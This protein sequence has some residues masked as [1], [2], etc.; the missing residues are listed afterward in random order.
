MKSALEGRISVVIPLF[1]GA[2]TLPAQLEGL[3]NQTYNGDWEVVI[4]DNGSTDGGP[5][6]ARE[7][8]DRVPQL[9]VVDASITL[10][11]TAARNIG[12]REASGVFIAYCDADDVVAPEWLQQLAEGA[13]S[14]D[15]VGG[16]LETASLN[17]ER[18]RSWRHPLKDELPV[19]MRFLPYALS[20]NLG[21]YK[22]VLL[23]LGGWN[24]V[25]RHG[26]DDIELCWRAQLRGYKLCWA[27]DA[28][29]HYRYRSELGSLRRQYFNYGY[30]EPRLYKTFRSD[31]ADR[32]KVRR[33]LK[34]WLWL[35]VKWP[36]CFSSEERRGNWVRLASYRWGRLR[37]S[38]AERVLYL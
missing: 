7:W 6:I 34:S 37:G 30:A 28:I 29:V 3:S 22:K 38:L 17:D 1:N 20:A 25:Y 2:S 33:A 21:I 23:D 5:E 16:K 9:R 11:A 4:A 12:A 8:A 15:L 10:G 24:E 27:E 19:A 31:G 32:S 26:A 18:S 35:A 14:C 36:G 13:V